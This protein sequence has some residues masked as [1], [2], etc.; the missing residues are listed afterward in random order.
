MHILCILFSGLVELIQPNVYA[1]LFL[2]LRITRIQIHKLKYWIVAPTTTD[3]VFAYILL[4]VNKS[5]QKFFFMIIDDN[6]TIISSIYISLQGLRVKT[7]ILRIQHDNF[8]LY[9][10]LN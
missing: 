3:I 9:S 2:L 10:H 5:I 1:V 6:L 4:V 8:I 7:F